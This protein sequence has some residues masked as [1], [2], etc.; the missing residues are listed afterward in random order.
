MLS[1]YMGSSIYKMTTNIGDNTADSNIE[2]LVFDE[3]TDNC[4]LVG[5]KVGY[6]FN[7]EKLDNSYS[8]VNSDTAEIT[9]GNIT[10][11]ITVCSLLK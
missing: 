7:A 4:C 2:S 1:K 10:E 3:K 11:S 5:T 8:V 9:Q 6:D